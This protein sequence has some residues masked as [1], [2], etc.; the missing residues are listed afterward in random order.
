MTT[1]PTIT[2]MPIAL[3]IRFISNA[4]RLQQGQVLAEKSSEVPG[5]QG[6]YTNSII[7]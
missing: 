3:P 6:A 2:P 4:R 5:H 1:T 7:T